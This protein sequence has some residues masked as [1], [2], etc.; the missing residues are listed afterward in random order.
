MKTTLSTKPAN[1]AVS[2]RELS[3]KLV[4]AKKRA[5]A[6]KADLKQARKAWKHA[7]KSAKETRKTAKALRKQLA[8]ARAALAKKAKAAKSRAVATQTKHTLRK[9]PGASNAVAPVKNGLVAP[10]S[11]L[12]VPV[13][14]AATDAPAA[15]TV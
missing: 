14:P 9:K 1:P 7:K 11:L 8:A 4:A 5:Q 13:Q 10:A 12:P 6:A 3:A 2:I 15:P